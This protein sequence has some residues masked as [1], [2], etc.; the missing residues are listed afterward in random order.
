L[1]NI[2][3][4]G[5]HLSPLK[6]IEVEGGN[7][8][9][10]LKKSDSSFQDFGE[11]Y[12]SCV[13]FNAIKAWKKHTRM[14]LNLIV[15]VGVVKFVIY[16]EK[17]ANQDKFNTITLSVDNYYRLTINPGLW[18]GFMGMDEKTSILLNIANIEHEPNEVENVPKSKFKYDWKGGK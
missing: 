11:A 2:D 10:A 5:V 8:M 12:F 1:N 9:H 18:V 4:D 14:T 17:D 13:H 15:P 7:V 16:D 3:I 6:N